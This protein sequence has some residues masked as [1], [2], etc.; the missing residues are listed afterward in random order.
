MER[1]DGLWAGYMFF[2][3]TSVKEGEMVKEGTILARA[4]GGEMNFWD[5]TNLSFRL[6]NKQGEFFKLSKE[7]F[8]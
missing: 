3:E 5:G 8:K 6:H 7:I 4:K 1:E 2:G